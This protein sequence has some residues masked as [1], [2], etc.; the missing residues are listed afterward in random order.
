M[1]FKRSDSQAPSRD[2]FAIRAR[3]PRLNSRK[4][5]KPLENPKGIFRLSQ[6]LKNRL[7]SLIGLGQHC[8]TGLSEDLVLG[9]IDS[10]IR[11]IGIADS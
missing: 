4:T 7:T 9:V 2:G 10:L 8:G 6:Q 3:E 11:H 1:Q 5:P